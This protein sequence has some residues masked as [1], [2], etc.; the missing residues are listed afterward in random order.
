MHAVAG[1]DAI[2]V[3][4][5][6]PGTGQTGSVR[7]RRVFEGDNEATKDLLIVD[8]DADGTIDAVV[9]L[10]DDNV[11]TTF[12]WLEGIARK[13]RIDDGSGVWRK[14]VG[15]SAFAVTTNC[16]APGQPCHY[17][18]TVQDGDD[19]LV[20]KL[21]PATGDT[22]AEV[23]LPGFGF[24]AIDYL[25]D[26]QLFRV[27]LA[28][29]VRLLAH[30][31][32][33]VQRADLQ[34]SISAAA[35]D[36]EGDY[37]AV[38]QGLQQF[39]RLN[40]SGTVEAMV[41]LRNSGLKVERALS[42]QPLAGADGR[43]DAGFVVAGELSV[44]NDIDRHDAWVLGLDGG[45]EIAWQ[46]RYQ[47]FRMLFR[48]GPS[49]QA[50]GL[51]AADLLRATAD[52][53]FVLGG[54]EGTIPQHAR[55][56]KLSATGSV[57]WI[58]RALAPSG[59]QSLRAVRVLAD[60]GLLVAGEV[61]VEPASEAQRGDG[62]PYGPWVAR[63]DADGNVQWTLRY[64]ALDAVAPG[65]PGVVGLGITDVRPAGDGALL[66]GYATPSQVLNRPTHAVAA[67]R[68]DAL[69][70]VLWANTYPIGQSSVLGNVRIAPSAD[71]GF[72]LAA[73]VQDSAAPTASGRLNVA[74]VRIADNGAVRWSQ[75]YGGLYD[76][77]VHGVEAL[78]DGGYLVSAQ[79]D[80]V[81]D[82]S[83]AWLLR[84]GADGRIVEGCNADRGRGVAVARSLPIARETYAL[85]DEPDAVAAPP[86]TIVDT[87]AV[88]NEP[89][90]VSVARQCIGTATGS[91]ATDQP[92]AALTVR[93]AG[94]LR[95][96]VTSIP[97]G[98]VCGTVG[99]GVC[100]APF[101]RGTLVTLRVD[102]GSV[103]N[104]SAWGPGCEAV[105]G[106]F[107][108]VCSVR[109]DSDKTIDVL[110]DRA[111]PPPPPAGEWRLTVTVDR[112]GA[113]IGSTDG[114]ISCIAS[115]AQPINTCVA[116]YPAG[117]VVEIY[118]EPLPASNVL[119]EAWQGDCASFGAQRLIRLTMDRHYHCRAAFVTRP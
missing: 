44:D 102:L 7:W 59:G 11:G 112:L 37:V 66:V 21:A 27:R 87:S 51:A 106:A 61:F 89:R 88:A 29:T 1:E 67:I 97:H 53:G 95:G 80:S 26:R 76:E 73:S 28:R 103:G 119:F 36:L 92:A 56:M 16:V 96:V 3:A 74:L 108:E 84:V 69:G 98:I 19:L 86:I 47:G 20:R 45:G 104:F 33:V 82:Y 101:A 85:P 38:D 22:E 57:A 81:G 107:G 30:D 23:V 14:R 63:L 60:H 118:A 48:S 6:D 15:G 25:A 10:T 72:V 68:I 117:R 50:F 75:L 99:G 93:H 91:G 8:D 9:T 114:S 31:L 111:P 42:I 4:R 18:A 17:V 65:V 13:L 43:S 55:L 62:V 78:A 70:N 40:A 39:R 12:D 116:S 115:G 49:S 54:H 109:L 46:K 71:G 41:S 35:P 2:H 77:I 34:R 64:A 100:S 83:D 24:P 90:D 79:S 32:T 113:F 58:T 105:S 110:F 5:I 94:T 52:G